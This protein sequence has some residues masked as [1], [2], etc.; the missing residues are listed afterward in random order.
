MRV[1]NLAKKEQELFRSTD[2]ARER[3]SAWELTVC[4]AEKHIKQMSD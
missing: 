1:V 2:E 3:E 4:G